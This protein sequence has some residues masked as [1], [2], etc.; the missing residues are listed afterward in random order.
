M[1]VTVR[2]SRDVVGFREVD[3]HLTARVTDAT[4]DPASDGLGLSV[5]MTTFAACRPRVLAVLRSQVAHRR[6]KLEAFSPNQRISG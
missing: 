5:V 1:G 3:A 6:D 4:L 2:W